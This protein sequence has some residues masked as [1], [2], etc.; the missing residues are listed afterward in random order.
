MIDQI[1]EGVPNRFIPP[2]LKAPSESQNDASDEDKSANEEL[3]HC[4]VI[5][6]VLLCR[7]LRTG[8]KGV[9]PGHRRTEIECES[10]RAERLFNI[11]QV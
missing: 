3:G 9:W 5:H 8:Q 4:D 7:D 11:A 6:L 2:V 10:V 1:Q